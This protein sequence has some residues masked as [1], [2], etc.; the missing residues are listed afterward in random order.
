[1]TEK[2]LSKSSS[3]NQKKINHIFHYTHE[4]ESLQKII[5]NGFSPSYCKEVIDE[6]DYFIP[7]VSFCNIPLKDVGL[8]MH[9]G[10]YGIGLQLDWA[11]RNSISPV[12]YIHEN[13]PFKSLH[14]KINE[15]L[16]R[17]SVDEV[18]MSK[19]NHNQSLNETNQLNQKEEFE[20][21]ELLKTINNITVPALQFFKNWKTTYKGKE[22]LTYQ[23]REWRFI[24]NLAENKRIITSIDSEYK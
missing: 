1:M 23:E 13:T 24:P 6:I 12:V 8:Y 21:I 4:F 2:I 11:I 3:F 22:I 14:R 20:F 10:D 17:K 7:M 5:E 16:I 9:Y 18:L 15:V 19:I